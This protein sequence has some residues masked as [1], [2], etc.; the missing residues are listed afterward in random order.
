MWLKESSIRRGHCWK[1]IGG[2]SAAP[3]H[4]H[5]VGSVSGDNLEA[6]EGVEPGVSQLGLECQAPGDPLRRRPEE[7]EYNGTN[8]EDLAPE[9]LGHVH[10]DGRSGGH[11]TSLAS[12]NYC[13]EDAGIVERKIG[14]FVYRVSTQSGPDSSAQSV[15]RLALLSRNVRQPNRVLAD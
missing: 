15:G 8:G 5:S 12:S 7:G 11:R 10:G 3:K 14:G 1:P 4:R 6:A 2:H 13:P 9:D